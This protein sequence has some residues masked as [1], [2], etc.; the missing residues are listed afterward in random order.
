MTTVS[1][2]IVLAAALLGGPLAL[3]LLFLSLLVLPATVTGP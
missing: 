2:V 3:P 1:I